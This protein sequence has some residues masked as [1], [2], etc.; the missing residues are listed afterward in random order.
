MTTST[1][2]ITLIPTGT[3]LLDPSHSSLS[4]TARHAMVTKVRGS[5]TA[6]SG[7]GKFNAEN[8]AESHLSVT[9]EAK[10]IDTHNADRDAHLKSNDFFDMENYPE[11]T[12]VSHNVTVVSDEDILI[13]GDLTI[14]GVTK[15]IS[16]PFTYT[17]TAVDPYGNTRVGLEGKVDVSRKEWGITWNAP[18]EAGGILVSD[19][20]ALEF[21]IS[22]IVTIS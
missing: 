16:I 21:D 14:K 9:I 3:Y 7:T 12:F 10:S 4:F 15:T 8:P 19:K 5:F 2:P 11:L 6:F 13:T 17:G 22:A 20:V 18:L 1:L